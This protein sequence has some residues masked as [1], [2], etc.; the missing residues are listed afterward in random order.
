M[1]Y[2]CKHAE[3]LNK[4][5]KTYSTL[6]LQYPI[7]SDE[8]IHSIPSSF[9]LESSFDVA[10][11]KIVINEKKMSQQEKFVYLYLQTIELVQIFID[12]YNEFE[13]KGTEQS[14]SSLKNGI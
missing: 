10:A 4:L 8:E 5:I 3:I 11:K 13:R 7:F 1:Q 2:I 12:I 9:V 14:L 6:N